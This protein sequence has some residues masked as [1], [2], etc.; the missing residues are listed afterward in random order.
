MLRSAILIRSSLRGLIVHINH[1]LV[2]KNKEGKWRM[3]KN[4]TRRTL[5][6]V[7]ERER[8]QKSKEN[9]LYL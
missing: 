5:E 7:R 3:K 2:T 4:K 9:R 1:C 6:V 8:E